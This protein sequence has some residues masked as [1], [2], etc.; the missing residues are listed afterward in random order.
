MESQLDLNAGKL[1]RFIV[2]THYYIHSHAVWYT[3]VNEDTKAQMRYSVS[4]Y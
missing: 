4:E 1:T 2:L 3:H